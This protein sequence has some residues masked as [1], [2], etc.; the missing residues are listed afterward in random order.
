[1]PQGTAV[2]GPRR[3]DRPRIR[4]VRNLRV[5]VAA[6]AR[7][8]RCQADAQR[9]A[10]RLTYVP[11]VTPLPSLTQ[12]VLIVP[13][14]AADRALGTDANVLYICTHSYPGPQPEGFLDTDRQPCTDP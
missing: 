12:P 14:G 10:A 5:L 6:P 7:S 13:P 8:S 4:I 11:R 2:P 1:M 9:V 3:S